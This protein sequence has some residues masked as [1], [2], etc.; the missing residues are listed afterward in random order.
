MK[1]KKRDMLLIFQLLIYSV[2]FIRREWEW[3]YSIVMIN[4]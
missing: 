2:V 4:D 3:L 1:K